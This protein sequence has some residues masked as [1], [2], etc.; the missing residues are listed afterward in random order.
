MKS[1][2]LTNWQ[3]ALIVIAFIAIN[4]LLGCLCESVCG[5]E[6]ETSRRLSMVLRIE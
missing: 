4:I 2:D 3:I 5:G 1:S 6:T